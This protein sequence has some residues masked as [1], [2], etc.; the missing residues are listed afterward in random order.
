M[1][2]RGHELTA[3]AIS[4]FV[5]VHGREAI[6]SSEMRSSKAFVVVSSDSTLQ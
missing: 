2:S 4:A 6:E 5:I 3:S 1:T